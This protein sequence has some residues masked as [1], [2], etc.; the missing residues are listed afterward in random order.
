MQSDGWPYSKSGRE[1]SKAP[2]LC[3]AVLRAAVFSF[4]VKIVR[5]D[6]NH[7]MKVDLLRD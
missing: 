2:S 1:S 6:R 7:C 3:A 5:S 4:E